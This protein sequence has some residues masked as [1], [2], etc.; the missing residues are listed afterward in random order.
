M[1]VRK[2]NTIFRKR[3]L[4]IAVS[5][6]VVGGLTGCSSDSDSAAAALYVITANGGLGGSLSSAEGGEGGTVSLYN[7]GGS[8]GVE[9]RNRGAANT[10]FTSPITPEAADL[11]AN[12][13]EITTSTTIEVVDIENPVADTD[14]TTADELYVGDD[15]IIRRAAG[16]AA[17]YAT[18]PVLADGTPYLRENEPSTSRMYIAGAG[19]A[20]SHAKVTG[21][22]VA[23]G[24]TVILGNNNPCDTRVS[25]VND[26][27]NN[28]I[29]TKQV[30]ADNC[31]LTLN[32]NKYIATGSVVNAGTEDFE[33]AG[34]VRIFTA[35][36]IANTGPI[37]TSGY[38]E[39]DEP[40]GDGGEIQLGA[41]GYVINSGALTAG[42]GNGTGAG[43]DGGEV[44]DLSAAY[45]ESAGDIDTRGGSDV[46]DTPV[47][48]G[49]DGGEA[50]INADYVTNNT[51]DIMTNGGNGT[52]GGD[53]GRIRL[54]NNDY[55]E[56][57]NSGS[58]TTAGGV[59]AAGSGGNG[60]EIYMTSR[61]GNLLNSGAVNTVGGDS[62][63]AT[64]NAGNGGDLDMFGY[65]AEFSDKAAGD[66]LAS[67]DI[68]L[69]GGN[70]AADGS[71]YG[72][73]AGD[74]DMMLYLGEQRLAQRVSLLGYVSID[75]NGG[76]GAEAGHG[77]GVFLHAD[78]AVDENDDG[79]DTDLAFAGSVVN[80]VPINGR[81]G[82][83]TS[84]EPL[85]QNRGG[86]GGEVI[87]LTSDAEVVRTLNVTATNTADIDL[88]GGSALGSDVNVTS[89]GGDGGEVNLRGFHG[90]TNS[91]AITLPG[92]IGGRNGGGGGHLDMFSI[93]GP[94]N[95]S[96]AVV[97][98]GADG[99]RSGGY[100]GSVDLFGS[101]AS[102]TA[103]INSNGGNA[104]DTEDDLVT[105]TGGY[106]G[107]ISIV[108]DG[109]NAPA[110]NSGTVTYEFGTGEVDGE[111]G[112]LQVGLTFEGNCSF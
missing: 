11:G 43:G 23:E 33:D 84:T 56:V 73:N 25:F 110:S 52:S 41:G 102:N 81:G 90:A 72:G 78:N 112:C 31:D 1:K 29:I 19:A 75:A 8:G 46:T 70:A 94:A 83:S 35:T 77:E 97:N 51:A 54:Y 45:V 63:D 59:G 64:S 9:V 39:D 71:G 76:N 48:S 89:P 3:E 50:I 22:S 57:K 111:A 21:L 79:D 96:G 69:N 93:S 104:T 61:G 66:I 6:A 32:S 20:A 68:N 80:D 85:V 99:A 87:M 106:G 18:D 107:E 14:P 26:I 38:T 7:E 60:G 27:D 15:G 103:D 82:N 42:G 28:G 36:G 37:N 5:L 34:D 86:D 109:L 2:Q 13:L 47:A 67:G 10:A 65:G 108:G 55:G 53:G 12:P 100:G 88:S 98:N 95:N 49:G 4:A 58:L 74:V 105:T 44:V 30:T 24:A 101:S 17:A 62:T 16:A 40:G 91:G 92:N